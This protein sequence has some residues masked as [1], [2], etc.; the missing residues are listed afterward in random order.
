[1]AVRL[2][3]FDL[4][5]TLVD[6]VGDLAAAVNATL[7]RLAP[8]IAALPVPTVRSFIG[9]GA[10]VL[11]A[12]SLAQA[13]LAA[14]PPDHVRPIFME[15]YARRLLDTT[16]LYPGVVEALD[17]L[18]DRR[19]AV[20][21]N[22]PGDMSRTILQGLGV[23][24]RFFRVHGGDDG[25]APTPDP[26]GLRQLMSEAAAAPGETVLVGDSSVDVRTARA[27]GVGALAVDYGFD[28]ESL[29]ADPPDALLSDLRGLPALLA[30]PSAGVLPS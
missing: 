24:G 3:V 12:R 14:V 1:V 6:S 20:L 4:D 8:G 18:A 21:T 25:T 23:A 15:E 11:V 22:K 2:V 28:R 29:A 10:R 9:N 5:G 16:R 7:Q 19:L 26:E 17:G 30:A 27:A 13:G